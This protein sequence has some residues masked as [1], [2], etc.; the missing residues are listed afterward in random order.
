MLDLCS[1]DALSIEDIAGGGR[2]LMHSSI[3][4]YAVH[5]KHAHLNVS[6]QIVIERS[7]MYCL[8]LGYVER[9]DLFYGVSR[10]DDIDPAHI[11]APNLSGSFG[12]FCGHDIFFLCSLAGKHCRACL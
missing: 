12:Y 10:Y 8:C 3:G 9:Q 6:V 11:H 2:D 5:G 4:R 1:P 7:P